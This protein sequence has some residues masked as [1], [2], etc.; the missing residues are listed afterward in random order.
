MPV[1][2]VFAIMILGVMVL[3]GLGALLSLL[4]LL[5]YL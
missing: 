1:R 5:G 2:A 3:S 4:Y